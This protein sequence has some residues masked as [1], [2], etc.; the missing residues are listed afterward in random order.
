M[1]LES[2]LQLLKSCAASHLSTAFLLTP[3]GYMFILGQSSR[4]IVLMNDF[5]KHQR[6]YT[7]KENA[8]AQKKAK[9]Q[10]HYN[11]S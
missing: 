1:N 9:L 7:L 2:Y 8:A 4:L 11:N 5:S 10:R 3:Q 6:C